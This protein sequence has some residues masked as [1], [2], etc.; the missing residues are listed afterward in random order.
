MRLRN[1][2]VVVLVTLGILA[3]LYGQPAG[4]SKEER[5]LM[6]QK[7][8]AAQQELRETLVLSRDMKFE[9]LAVLPAYQ[10]CV[11][12]G[13][14]FHKESSDRV[15]LLKDL[16]EVA[17]GVEKEMEA[18]L[19]S[20]GGR[21]RDVFAIRYM[22]LDAELRLLREKKASKEEGKLMKQKLDTA[23]MEIDETLKLSRGGFDLLAA[24][25]AYHRC[26]DAGLELYQDSTDRINLLE[27]LVECAK[28]FEKNAEQRFKGGAGTQRDLYAIRYMRLDA[29]SRLLREKNK[30]SK[31][32]RKLMNQKLETAQMELAAALKLSRDVK[33]DLLGPLHAHQRYLDAGL[34]FYQEATDRV[35]LLEDLVEVAKGVDKQMEARLRGGAGRRIDANAIRYM[36]LDAELRLLRE[37]KKAK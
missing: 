22:R 31:E 7:L 4:P 5:K 6:K 37:K 13:M 21:Q 35:K 20:G 27:G 25:P 24:L 2:L 17:K 18:R 28:A 8:E 14:E 3:P 33:F 23:Q 19:K 36:R 34:E 16:V 9:V 1:G 12:A 15:K 11:D 10:R 30:A 26:V 32:V 29:Q